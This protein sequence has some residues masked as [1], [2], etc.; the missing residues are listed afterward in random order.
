MPYLS[1]CAEVQKPP[2]KPAVFAHRMRQNGAGRILGESMTK[3]RAVRADS[4][5]C[6]FRCKVERGRFEV[7]MLLM[8]SDAQADGHLSGRNSGR[9]VT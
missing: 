4:P 9:L 2:G 7:H 5:V 3:S 8:D 1:V 6:T